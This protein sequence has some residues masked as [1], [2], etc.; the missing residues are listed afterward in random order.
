MTRPEY[1]VDN[2]VDIDLDCNPNLLTLSLVDFTPQYLIRLLSSLVT[3]NL[4][5]VTLYFNDDPHPYEPDG[6]L[7]IDRILNGQ[8]SVR[9]V[10]IVLA[11]DP[12]PSSKF[13]GYSPLLW[14]R[15]ILKITYLP[16]DQ[17]PFVK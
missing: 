1:T 9:L 13:I 7:E 14:S 11:F 10:E 6:W 17:W 8:A 5:Q 2:P 15:G 16:F 4:Q 12:T 3:P